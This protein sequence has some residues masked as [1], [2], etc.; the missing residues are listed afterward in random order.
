[1]AKLMV[2]E[3]GRITALVNELGLKQK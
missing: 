3:Q 1:M 2:E